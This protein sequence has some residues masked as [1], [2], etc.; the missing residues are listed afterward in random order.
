MFVIKTLHKENRWE[1]PQPDKGHLQKF[2][3]NI[4][5]Y[6]EKQNAFPP[7][8]RMSALT[9]TIQHCTGGSSQDNEKI[10]IKSIQIGKN[11]VKLSPPTDDM[12]LY[13]ENPRKS[14]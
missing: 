9:N 11:K 2:R 7:E 6:G 5:L 4:I 13:V 12:N 10:K 3:A 8:R 14:T 1:L